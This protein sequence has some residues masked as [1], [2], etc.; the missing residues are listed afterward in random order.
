MRVF[1]Y[2]NLQLLRLRS[3]STHS[4][5]GTETVLAK[6]ASC[7]IENGRG[8]V[9]TRKSSCSG[10]RR[11]ALKRTDIFHLSPALQLRLHLQTLTLSPGT[12]K[13]LHR[14][15]CDSK[16]PSSSEAAR[17]VSSALLITGPL[18]VSISDSQLTLTRVSV[19][20]WYF[21]CGIIL[22]LF[23][24]EVNQFL[25]PT[26]WGGGLWNKRVVIS[27]PLLEKMT[28]NINSKP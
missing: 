11:I 14:G 9:S 16:R 2:G 4:T 26:R 5:P 20:F 18:T 28:P 15:Q 3:T 21:G 17:D 23:P 10:H 19:S 25:E 1:R 12:L 7:V 13:C 22:G 27:T 6:L 24:E 8:R